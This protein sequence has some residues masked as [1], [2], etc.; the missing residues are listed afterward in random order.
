[1]KRSP[2]FDI[3]MKPTMLR[4]WRILRRTKKCIVIQKKR[5]YFPFREGSPLYI[6]I[7]LIE[8]MNEVKK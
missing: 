5:D 1:M 2:L 4:G 7:K 3:T 6:P 8:K